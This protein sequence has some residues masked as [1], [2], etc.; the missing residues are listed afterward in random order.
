[1]AA[2][3]RQVLKKKAARDL[4]HSFM[5]EDFIKSQHF[6]IVLTKKRFKYKILK[7]GNHFFSLS[8]DLFHKSVGPVNPEI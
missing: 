2:I 7:I 1:M 6:Q 4:P 5:P 3:Q 8:I